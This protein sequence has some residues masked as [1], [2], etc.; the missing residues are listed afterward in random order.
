MQAAHLEELH[1]RLEY[2]QLDY[3]SFMYGSGS[4][5]PNA[6]PDDLY[7]TSPAMFDDVALA[8]TFFR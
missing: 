1:D 6:P 3:T 4:L 2:L 8:N 5:G 7:S